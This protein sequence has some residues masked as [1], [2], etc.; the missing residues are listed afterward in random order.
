VG[1]TPDEVAQKYQE[2]ANDPEER[3]PYPSWIEARRAAELEMALDEIVY[4]ALLRLAT[5]GPESPLVP[6][7]KEGEQPGLANAR[8]VADALEGLQQ[9]YRAACRP[10]TETTPSTRNARPKRSARA[11]TST[12]LPNNRFDFAGVTFFVDHDANYIYPWEEVQ[13]QGVLTEKATWAA[14]RTLGE[15]FSYPQN[16]LPRETAVE[17]ITAM[18]TGKEA[19]INVETPLLCIFL[20]SFVA[21]PGRNPVAGITN[22]MIYAG[23][24]DPETRKTANENVFG[25]M[26]MTK[27]GTAKPGDKLGDYDQAIAKKRRGTTTILVPPKASSEEIRMV[28]RAFGES[29]R[30]TLTDLIVK[31]EV[32]QAVNVVEK[33]LRE[34]IVAGAGTLG[35]GLPKRAKPRSKVGTD[36]TPPKSNAS[37]SPPVPQ[38]GTAGVKAEPSASEVSSTTNTN[39]P[40]TATRR[41]G[42]DCL[43]DA[44]NDAL[45]NKDD[46]VEAFRHIAS[47]WFVANLPTYPQFAEVADFDRIVETLK[48]PGAWTGDAGDLSPLILASSLDVTLNIVTP[49]ATH[50]YSPLGSASQRAVTVY[51]AGNHYTHVPTDQHRE[52][53][54]QPVIHHTTESKPKSS[55]DRDLEPVSSSEK[56]AR[57]NGPLSD[58]TPLSVWDT[59]ADKRKRLV[60]SI[61]FGALTA[62]LN[63]EQ[64]AKRLAWFSTFLEEAET[65][66]TDTENDRAVVC[67]NLTLEQLKG[68]RKWSD[69]Q[70]SFPEQKQ[71]WEEDARLIREGEKRSRNLNRKLSNTCTGE[72]LSKH[73]IGYFTALEP[74]EALEA[75][76]RIATGRSA[77]DSSVIDLSSLVDRERF[78][79]EIASAGDKLS[80]R[81]KNAYPVIHI[82]QKGMVRQGSTRVTITYQAGGV[83][84]SKKINHLD[85]I[86]WPAGREPTPRPWK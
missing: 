16:P 69:L 58:R 82:D 74:Q 39:L 27:G 66:W 2:W 83:K 21:E 59:L 11:A 56:S 78:E 13:K 70:K 37:Q 30:R 4:S 72:F 14:D 9:R 77:E 40:S 80:F 29:G 68:G 75:A 12:P 25:V 17:I 38:A 52:W 46:N 67:P 64:R 54:S 24:L 79:E 34:L 19:E 84:T 47:Q 8:S 33:R 81:T 61:T 57:G 3:L 71:Q 50:V 22:L 42:G 49:I 31:K 76:K 35:K 20:A 53:K 41:K 32:D 6:P 86:E 51:H 26:P 28:L 1:Q 62:E 60:P 44:V 65:F 45:G 10:A 5:G 7:A 63:D 55:E 15:K 48:T 18:A 85:P 36:V 43:Y 23:V 73:I